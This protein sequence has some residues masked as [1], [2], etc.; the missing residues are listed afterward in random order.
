MAHVMHIL[1]NGS[2]LLIPSGSSG[3]V[4]AWLLLLVR[5]MRHMHTLP[6][7]PDEHAALLITRTLSLSCNVR[8]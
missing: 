7:R 5:I 8:R 3:A 2:I 4:P 6:A 1:A